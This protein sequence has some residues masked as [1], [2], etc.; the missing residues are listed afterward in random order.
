MVRKWDLVVVSTHPLIYQVIRVYKIPNPVLL[1]GSLITFYEAAIPPSVMVLVALDVN[2][3]RSY[4]PVSC[5]VQT[6]LRISILV[7]IGVDRA[8]V[9]LLPFFN[10]PLRFIF[11]EVCFLNIHRFKCGFKIEIS[12]LN[13]VLVF[14]PFEITWAKEAG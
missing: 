5:M 12:T 4:T 3:L 8:S 9:L 13:L 2:R 6:L 10:R 1:V 7:F 14:I 11:V